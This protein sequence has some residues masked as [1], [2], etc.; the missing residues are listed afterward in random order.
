MFCTNCGAKMEASD[1][2]CGNCG[3]A[4]VDEPTAEIPAVEETVQEEALASEIL[5]EAAEEAAADTTEETVEETTEEVMAEA[6]EEAPEEAPEQ[7][8]AEPEPIPEP[9]PE[10][11]PEPTPEPIPVPQPQPAPARPVEKVRRKPHIALR[12][13]MQFL[14]LILCLVLTVTLL[15]TVAL[16]DVKL[17]LSEDGMQQLFQ[18]LL[19]TSTSQPKH[20]AAGPGVIGL[21]QHRP[22]YAPDY[23]YD[24]IPED[25]DV[26]ALIDAVLS[27][28][29]NL[30]SVEALVG[31]VYEEL[32]NLLDEEL[33]FTE[34]ELLSFVKKS[35]I[36]DYVASK[37]SGFTQDF[38]NGTNKTT[39]TTKELEKLVEENIDLYEREFHTQV[40]EESRSSMAAALDKMVNEQDLNQV[41][42]DKVFSSVEDAIN[43]AAGETGV[44]WKEIQ[45]TLKILNADLT[46][47]AAIAICLLLVLLMCALNF[48]NVPAGL[49][50][51]AVPFLFLGALLTLLP[52]LAAILPLPDRVHNLLMPLLAVF[53]RV[54]LTV[55]II[56][57][58]LLVAGIIWRI[59][60]KVLRNKRAVQ[61]A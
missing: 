33:L 25:V 48:Y 26:Q 7:P 44:T 28:P 58:V 5:P 57:I 55:L 18:E 52:T 13:L 29:D 10:P 59:V 8:V 16:A 4:V 30:E 6:A 35:T 53:Q 40:D 39:I 2:F 20:T 50:W 56:G 14:S 46:L 9:E 21:A 36:A 11:M 19:N 43:E 15:A 45:K 24:E 23:L 37:L 61:T 47:Y 41:V 32:E 49:T 60:R 42:Q 17:V 54:H 3:A 51:S 38:I 22:L 34:E 12:V 31:A 27:D 1:R